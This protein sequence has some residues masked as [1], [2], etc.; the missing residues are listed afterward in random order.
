MRAAE[1]VVELDLTGASTRLNSPA[2]VADAWSRW[3]PHL[4]SGRA[5]P[6]TE[7]RLTVDEGD[8]LVRIVAS[9]VPGHMTPQTAFTVRRVVVPP[10]VTTGCTTCRADGRD[11]YAPYACAGCTTTAPAGKG[12][13]KSGRE[14]PG[15]ACEQ[16]VVLLRNDHTTTCVRHRP[17]CAS[18]CVRPAEFWCDGP[19][20]R[21]RTAHCAAHAQPDAPGDRLMCRRCYSE[22]YPACGAAGCRNT[23]TMRCDWRYGTSSCSGRHC[24]AHGRQWQ[25]LG[26][27]APGLA[28]CPSHADGLK[29]YQPRDVAALVLN[30]LAGRQAPV[31]R[32][33][34][35]PPPAQV[36]SLGMFRHTFI[37]VCGQPLPLRRVQA[38]VLVAAEQDVGQRDV[39]T[40]R[41]ESVKRRRAAWEREVGNDD[42]A[43]EDGE[44]RFQRALTSW[45]TA[46]PR[47]AAATAYVTFS[48]YRPAKSLLFVRCPDE[49]RAALIGKGGVYI[50]AAGEAAGARITWE[51]K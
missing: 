21:R 10:R 8:V 50:T 7:H 27:Y 49:H 1:V 29:A 19:L 20:C 36:P 34:G 4:W 18:D 12:G 42:T 38:T 32:G 9:D 14:T 48:D 30:G 47:A 2:E 5:E 11:R 15:R 35:A 44:Q 33:K 22:Q 26:P 51:D 16:H 45:R 37:N 6:G 24:A 43:Q 40:R 13:T 46:S 17:T 25:V 3:E 23:G 41:R 39:D 28:L 31:R